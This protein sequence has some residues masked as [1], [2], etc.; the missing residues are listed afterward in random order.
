M[1]RRIG[2]VFWNPIVEKELRSRMRSGRASL[3]ISIYLVTLAAVGFFT[4]VIVERQASRGVSNGQL[5]VNAGITIF[6]ALTGWE[7]VLIFFIAP[8]LTATAI[9]GER[10]RQ[11]LDLL[12]CT[13]V[14]PSAIV[15]G[16]LIASL[17]FALL[18]LVASVPVFSMV[19]LFGGVE[20]SQV[21]GVAATLGVT[22]VVIGAI[23]LACS[24]CIR[25]PTAATV[26]A[27]VLS[28]LYILVPLATSFIFP[29]TFLSTSAQQY[30]SIAN[31]G[32]TLYSTLFDAPVHTLAGPSPT[33]TLTIPAAGP[34]P[35]GIVV[36][37][38]SPAPVFPGGFATSA[39]S[40]S[41][42]VTANGSTCVGASG[43]IGPLTNPSSPATTKITV[44]V[45]TPETDKIQ[46][47][48]FHGWRAWQAYALMSALFVALLVVLSVTVLSRSLARLPR[49]RRARPPAPVPAV[50]GEAP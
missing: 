25:R 14:R 2:R 41:C 13:R 10:E 48:L 42:T 36:S 30:A 20:L 43:S 39:P 46:A 27:Y 7:L 5:S 19:F 28:F 18:L 9:A 44:N 24:V 37:P 47:G 34:I 38:P 50:A 8:V 4:Y 49:R 21:V 15:M 12:L 32:Y 22:A 35:G 40:L 17:L 29:T 1:I 11:T 33:K 3:L 45:P 23:G 26:S 16:K 31:P 6:R